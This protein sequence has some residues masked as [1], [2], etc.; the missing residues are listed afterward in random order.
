MA[1]SKINAA[2]TEFVRETLA[3]FD[4][5]RPASALAMSE[6]LKEWRAVNDMVTQAIFATIQVAQRGCKHPRAQRGSN[7][8]DGDW[9]NRCPDCGAIS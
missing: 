2:A 3:L 4:P 8:R 5:L 7:E 6:K 9:M 1:D